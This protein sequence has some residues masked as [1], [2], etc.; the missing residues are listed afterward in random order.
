MN[1]IPYLNFEGNCKEAIAYYK[2]ILDGEVVYMQLYK[3]MPPNDEMPIPDDYM[4][5]ILHAQFVANDMVIYMSDSMPMNP[6]IKG[7]QVSLTIDFD[8]D[9]TLDQIYNNF[10]DTS[11][12]TMPLQDTF[13]G[14]RFAGLIDK[15]GV[16]WA[17]NHSK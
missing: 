6:L 14:A 15:Y 8:D 9:S 3:D 7:N 1:L 11:Q 17:L 5:K 10:K 12:I 13:W 16:V 2:E 4:D